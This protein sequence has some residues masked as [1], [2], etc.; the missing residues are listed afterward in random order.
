M[1]MS[2]VIDSEATFEQQA[3]E[4]G[5]S[6][7]WIDALKTS[8]LATMA[9]LS[10]AVTTPGTAATDGDVTTF[11]RSIRAGVA[12]AISD[13]ASFKRILFE[14]QTLM[15]HHLKTAVKGDDVSV[16]KMAPP[17]REARLAQQRGLL[18]GLDITGPLEPAHALYDLC[19]DMIE[20]NSIVYISPSKC[21]SR[22]QELAGNK[23][24]KEIQLDA[25]K[26][27]LVVKEPAA[28]TDISIASDLALFQAIQRR[29]L[30]M[31]LTGLATYEVMKKWTDRLFNIYSQAV[32][33]GFQKIS[34]A[35]LLR[36]DRQAFVRLGELFTG[37]LK[38]VAAPGKVL[39]P[40]IAQLENDV[41]VTYFML[42]LPVSHAKS[43]SDDK[44]NKKRNDAAVKQTDDAPVVK[45][46]KKSAKGPGSRLK[47]TCIA[48]NCGAV[49]AL[50]IK[51]DGQH[52]HAPWLV[53]EGVFD[54]SL[55]AE[56]T[57]ALAKAL[58]QCVFIAGEFKLPNIQQ[59]SK[60]LKL[61]HFSAIAAAKQPTKPVAMALVPEFS[62]LVV[63]SNIPIHCELPIVD[64]HLTKCCNI[65]A[66]DQTVWIPCGCKLL[67]QTFKEGGVSRQSKFLVECTPN[68][69]SIGD[70]SNS[71]VQ[72]SHELCC[73]KGC[74][75]R[76]QFHLHVL[77]TMEK[78]HDWVL[79][80]VWTPE[81]FLHQ[82]CQVDHPFVSFSGLPSI[83]AR[84]CDDVASMKFEDIV[85]FRCS[86]LGSWLK[87]ANQLKQDEEK[88]KSTMSDSRRRILDPKRLLLMKHIIT[89][90]GYD[91]VGLAD[92]LIS[93]FSLVGEVPRSHVL[94]QKMTPSTLRTADLKS[95]ASKA[96]QALR[97][98]TRS[99]GDAD[100]DIKLWDRTQVELSRGWLLGPLS[101]DQL[102]DSAV[103][104]RRFPINQSEKV[105]PIDDFFQSQINYEKAT[106]D[107]PDVICALAV[108]LMKGL[109]DN[110]RS[111]QLLGRAL[112]LASA[113]RQLAVAED[114]YD[115]AFLSI[116]NPDTKEAALYQQVALPFG[117]VTAVN[118]FIRCSRFLQWTASHCLKLPM[119]CYFDDFVIFSPPELSNNS[120]ST[121]SL[122]LDILGWAFDKEGPKSDNFSARVSA[123]GVVFNLDPTKDCR[124][125]V[126]NT[127]KRLSEAVAALDVIL[128]SRKLS[129]KDALSLRG[130]LAFCDAFIFGRLGRVSL[131]KITHH[132]YASPFIAELNDSM[133]QSLWYLEG[134]YEDC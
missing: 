55:E 123:L 93:G 108:K 17:E 18:R 78:C 57:P 119:S 132:A 71:N 3:I 115:V 105:R 127:D 86:K 27:S 49:M 131:Q 133:V 12:P 90:E 76:Q 94:P 67:R 64:K 51:C 11:L 2:S 58:A 103:V 95:N 117:S 22:Q 45:P 88:L 109:R 77:E 85:N 96:N 134:S 28:S 72:T 63:L 50:A 97:Y 14:A 44:G 112:D 87:L 4:A 114:S 104:S 120:Q 34:Q 70:S 110:G 52:T 121:L 9:K 124:L 35:Q 100:L 1:A 53:K 61:S 10:F 91:D 92:D 29:S 43:D 42:P 59:F 101:W 62:H 66:G 106:V 30:A 99:S 46:P 89:S 56:Y 82:A 122:T 113:Y 73:T 15:V 38:Q 54:T 128:Q 7:P 37:S 125:E 26:T 32:A 21:M 48:S 102:P 84:A 126:H 98:M 68:L 39:D 25:T 33:P 74:K 111:S 83:V 24:E 107:G 75:E 31:D 40:Y 81:Q 79:G 13:L 36:A 130:R 8:G 60:R 5:L 20:K 116:F 16:K 129:K 47:R 19:S 80:V 23:P 69:Q 65:T 118:A 6:Q 41:T